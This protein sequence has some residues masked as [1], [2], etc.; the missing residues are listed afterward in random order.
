MTIRLDAIEAG[1]CPSIIVYVNGSVVTMDPESPAVQAF[2][3][4]DGKFLCVGTNEE[5]RALAAS[6]WPR[7]PGTGERIREVDLDGATVLPGLIDCHVHLLEFGETL[8]QLDLSDATSSAQVTGMVAKRV[9]E[10]LAGDWVV[11][12]RW[13]ETKWK[14]GKEPHRDLLDAIAPA[15]PVFLSRIDGHTALVNSQV[16]LIAGISRQTPD[17]PGGRIVRDGQTGEPTG[18]LLDN[19]RELVRMLMPKPSRATKR[20]MLDAAIRE[21]TRQG[22]TCVHDAMASLELQEILEEMDAS[23]GLPLRI[24]LML[25]FDEFEKCESVGSG[26]AGAGWCNRGLT[27]HTG[28]PGPTGSD[29]SG[30]TDRI[31]STRSGLSGFPSPAGLSNSRATTVTARTVKIFADGALG[32][33]GALLTEPY[34]DDASTR[35]VEMH[36]A[37]ELLGMVRRILRAGLQPAIHAIGDLANSRVLDVYEQCSSET[38]WAAARPRL[39]HA[40]ILTEKDVERCGRLG[41]FVC[42]QPLQLSSDMEWMEQRLGPARARRSFL[43]TSVARAGATLISGSDVPIESCDPFLGLYA[44]VTRKNLRGEPPDGWLRQE[45]LSREAALKTYTLDAAYAGFE[46]TARGSIQKGKSADFVVVD[47]DVLAVPEEEILKTRVLA[48]FSR[49]RKTE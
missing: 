13:N 28:R 15:N 32:S 34:S 18:V 1:D 9:R 45:S 46:E 49:G 30:H 19:A 33:R 29:I 26:T 4:Q 48:T 35:G 14:D 44:A 8:L 37:Q 6:L 39:E 17:P 3:V 10:S 22:L 25:T 20:R 12:N 24:N 42:I 7:Q 5:A 38:G 27:G 40:Q 36:G 41:L 2:A 21:L 11:G 47:K 23:D 43:W 16:L 31:G